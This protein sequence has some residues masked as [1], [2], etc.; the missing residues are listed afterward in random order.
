MNIV[1]VLTC[2][3]GVSLAAPTSDPC[4][5]MLKTTQKCFTD[6]GIPSEEVNAM[7]KAVSIGNMAGMN[8]TNY[9]GDRKDAFLNAS[10][11]VRDAVNT[12]SPNSYDVSLNFDYSKY[13]DALCTDKNIKLECVSHS[14][15][16]DAF[17]KCIKDEAARQFNS[18]T[19]SV[20]DQ[21]KISLSCVKTV[22]GACDEHTGEFY[23]DFMQPTVE[24]ACKGNTVLG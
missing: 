12:C 19:V 23:H 1:V 5:D 15:F 2:I 17:S 20:C 21:G 18:T 3:V 10:K 7:I 11:C 13:M 16:I 24:Q 4:A 9:C 6:N 14:G 22:V 8:F